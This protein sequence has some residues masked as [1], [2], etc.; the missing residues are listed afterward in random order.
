MERLV[1][2]G[3]SFVESG[4][5]LQWQKYLKENLKIKGKPLFKGMRC[6]LTARGSGPEL[7]DLIPLTPL[8]VIKS[9]M[10][11]IAKLF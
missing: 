5:F 4:D 3:K 9:R 6:V 1:G 2:E 7:K 11:Q 10:D 8:G